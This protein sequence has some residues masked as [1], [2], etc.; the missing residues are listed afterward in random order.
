MKGIL[1]SAV[2][3]IQKKRLNQKEAGESVKGIVEEQKP[4]P[5]SSGEGNEIVRNTSSSRSSC[6]RRSH[7]VLYFLVEQ[8]MREIEMYSCSNEIRCMP[9]STNL[10]YGRMLDSYDQPH[11]GREGK[12][13]MNIFKD[14]PHAFNSKT[15]RI[16]DIV[17]FP[18]ESSPSFN[19]NTIV[20]TTTSMQTEHAAGI[21]RELENGNEHRNEYRNEYKH[22]HESGNGLGNGSEGR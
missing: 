2:R 12:S 17:Y 16:G 5:S 10:S 7:V 9:T 18:R 15:R 21:S 13:A 14:H 19:M 4:L 20:G 22:T 8:S 6:V 11:S 1:C 3:R